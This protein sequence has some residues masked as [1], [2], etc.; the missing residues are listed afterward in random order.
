[1]F[2]CA[3]RWARFVRV[4]VRPVLKADQDE[5]SRT[6]KLIVKDVKENSKWQDIAKQ[7]AAC[8]AGKAKSFS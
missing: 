2:A 6:R 3:S 7:F 4:L 1:M 8:A 5:G